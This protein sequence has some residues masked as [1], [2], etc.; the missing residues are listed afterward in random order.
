MNL[1]VGK[2]RL[3]RAHAHIV[4]D[5]KGYAASVKANPHALVN[6]LGFKTCLWGSKSNQY[7]CRVDFARSHGCEY[8]DL[9]IQPPQF[10]MFLPDECNA[11]FKELRDPAMA[12]QVW[13]RKS[14]DNLVGHSSG[15][16]IYSPKDDEFLWAHYRQCEPDMAHAEHDIMMLYMSNTALISANTFSPFSLPDRK[17]DVRIF[18]LV[19]S[20]KPFIVFYADGFARRAMTPY[21]VDPSQSGPRNSSRSPTLQTPRL[22]ITRA[23]PR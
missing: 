7:G 22:R 2:D 10:R 11:F 1:K 13:V 21:T 6:S 15:S 23:R 9:A 19:A 18:L 8:K 4:N 3:R 16:K 14:G 5:V 20:A 17:F 12:A